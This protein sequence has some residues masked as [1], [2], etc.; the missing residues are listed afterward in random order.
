MILH[1]SVTSRSPHRMNSDGSGDDYFAHT[2]ISQVT[3]VRRAVGGTLR[4]TPVELK[5]ELKE[6]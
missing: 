4:D 5:T 2:G 6:P 1:G 3:V